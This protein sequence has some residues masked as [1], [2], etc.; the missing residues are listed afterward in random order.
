MLHKQLLYCI[1]WGIMMGNKGLH[2]FNS[3]VFF[4]S[5][6]FD[7]WLNLEMG[8]PQI[9]KAYCTFKQWEAS[10]QPS[11]ILLPPIDSKGLDILL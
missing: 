11:F 9:W 7:S 4:F 10:E 1:V 3:D 5:N 2:L 8:N 6:I